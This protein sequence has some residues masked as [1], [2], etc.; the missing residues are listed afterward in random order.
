[1]VHKQTDVHEVQHCTE[2]R[3][4]VSPWSC[5]R[6]QAR[7]QS[8]LRWSSRLS[9]QRARLTRSAAPPPPRQPRQRA[10][11]PRRR[12]PRQQTRLT[13]RA[14]PRRHARASRLRRRPRRPRQRVGPRVRGTETLLQHTRIP[15]RRP[16]RAAGGLSRR[17]LEGGSS[18][19]VRCAPSPTARQ[20]W[21]CCCRREL[22]KRFPIGNLGAGCQGQACRGRVRGGAAGGSQTRASQNNRAA[23]T[24]SG[25]L[26]RSPSPCLALAHS[27]RRRCQH[28]GDAVVHGVW[29][30]EFACIVELNLVRLATEGGC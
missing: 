13:P 4:Y 17:A 19:P 24:Q 14:R 25:F 1:V 2:H 3:A 8:S 12:R 7:S 9:P 23:A 16:G 20:L 26:A 11:R 5:C 28:P 18:R 15:G 22:G 29:Q 21:Q 6:A 27:R 30:A 10:P